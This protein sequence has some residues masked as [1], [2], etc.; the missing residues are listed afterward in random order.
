[1]FAIALIIG[2]LAGTTILMAVPANI[3]FVIAL[4]LTVGAVLLRD[5]RVKTVVLLMAVAF[6]G[7]GRAVTAVDALRERVATMEWGSSA[8]AVASADDVAASG[9]DSHDETFTAFLADIRVK[10]LRILS[11]AGL[12]DDDYAVAAAMTLGDR[13]GMTGELKDTYSQAGA[14]HVLAL[15]GMHIAIVFAI[16]SA[17]ILWLPLRLTLLPEWLVIRY[18]RSRA[19]RLFRHAMPRVETLKVILTLLA[20]FGI[21]CYALLV[22]MS[23]SVVRS[24]FMLSVCSLAYLLSRRLR[25]LNSLALAASVLLILNPLSVY[26]VGF[27]MSFLAVLGIALYFIPLSNSLTIHNRL[28]RWTWSVIALTLSAQVMVLP[29]TA[30]YFHRIACLGILSSLVVAIG[31]LLIVWLSLATITVGFLSLNVLLPLLGSSLSLCISTQNTIL[32]YITHIPLA[33]ID[34]IQVSLPQLLLIY[35]IIAAL[36]RLG[37]KCV[38]SLE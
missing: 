23:A 19:V 7:C 2:I 22:G 1:M 17:I 13:S 29:L 12:H 35:I 10:A 32:T 31:A 14:S 5:R 11:D 30:F 27:Q 28:L 6:V 37:R 20:L 38:R 15:S 26:D 4:V 16:F 25:L 9:A 3:C 21:W 8:Q 24:A 34:G 18:P 33:Y 36:D